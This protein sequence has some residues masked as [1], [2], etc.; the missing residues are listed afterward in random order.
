MRRRMITNDNV[1]YLK[2][3][4]STGTQYIDTGIPVTDNTIIRAS[5]YIE[6]WHKTYENIF[7]TA[8]N[9]CACIRNAAVNEIGFPLKG[10]PE[11]TN[12]I[13]VSLPMECNVIIDIAQMTYALN[14]QQKKY[15]LSMENNF[16]EYPMWIFTKRKSTNMSSKIVDVP[17]SFKLY[18]FSMEESGEKKIDLYP[19]LDDNGIPCLIDKVSNQYFYNH[20]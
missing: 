2:S 6:E 11:S 4:I 7:G 16:G 3:L 15:N 18:S 1:H 17:G 20:G 12:K 13:P 5:F 8:M 14:E 9:L 10:T 19:T